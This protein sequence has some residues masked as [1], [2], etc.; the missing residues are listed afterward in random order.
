MLNWHQYNLCKIYVE[1]FLRTLNSSLSP[2]CWSAYYCRISLHLFFSSLSLSFSSRNINQAQHPRPTCEHLISHQSFIVR[3]FFGWKFWR[4]TSW[5]VSAVKLK[6]FY[7]IVLWCFIR[8]SRH[9][10]HSTSSSGSSSDDNDSDSSESD[11]DSSGSD[12]NNN[13]KD[14]SIKSPLK[15]PSSSP[16]VNVL[17]GENCKIESKLQSIIGCLLSNKIESCLWLLERHIFQEKTSTV[18]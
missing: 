4:C 14:K 12:T 13:T 6:I 2:C 5:G 17:L 18:K 3:R 7:E 16:K 10:S 11:S 15:S 8:I 1:G 9:R